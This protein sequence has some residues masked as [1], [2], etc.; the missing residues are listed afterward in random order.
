MNNILV[1]PPEP[2]AGAPLSHPPIG[3]L[4]MDQG[5]IAHEDLMHALELQRRID[6]PLGDIMVSEGL[7]ERRDVLSALAVQARTQGADLLLHPPARE[8]ARTLPVELCL[9]YGVVPWRMDARALYVAPASPA[10]FAALRARMQDTP[11]PIFPVIV[12][13]SQIGAQ[14]NRLYGQELARK[15]AER[16]PLA[17][18]CR[19]WDVAS[20]RRSRWSLAVVAGAALLAL[21]AP[22]LTLTILTLLATLML[23]MTTSLKLAALI[24]HLAP[25]PAVRFLHRLSPASMLKRLKPSPRRPLP[26]DAGLMPLGAAHTDALL[27]AA[28]VARAGKNGGLPVIN[29]ADRPFRLPRVSV[30]VPLLREREIADQLIARLSRLTYPKSLLDVVLVLEAGDELTRE[31]IARTAL[32]DWMRVIEVP[33][34]GNLTTKPRAL[35][36]ALDFCRGSIIGVWDAEDWPENDQIEKVVARFAKA[37]PDVACLQ[38]ALDYYNSRTNWLT[39]CFAIEYAIWWRVVLP[40]I[41]RLGLVVPLGGTTLFFRRVIL[42]ELGGWDAHNVTEDA[43]LGV[44]LARHGYRTELLATVTREEATSR[45]WPWVRQRSRWLKGFLITYLVHMRRPRGLLRDLGVWR[46]MGIQVLFLAS[47][48]QF[49]VAPLLWSFWL[50]LAGMSHPV[51]TTLGETAIGGMVAIFVVAETLGLLLGLVAVSH[52]EHRHLLPFLPTMMVY[53][54]LGTLA[55][56]KALWELVRV[57]FYWDKTQHGV[58]TAT[59]PQIAASGM[60][61]PQRSS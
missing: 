44:R 12:D 10:R 33:E 14:Q 36:Y 23:L 55:A 21:A 39:R 37:P 59:D 24:A 31:T 11:V 30:L 46:F 38:G 60:D 40:G 25:A 27:K 26:P 28:A 47:V 1:P 41:A 29:A 34:A 42:E 5:K 13:E 57:P 22:A 61:V 58:S 54:G 43:D 18:S 35:N 56:Y 45:P 48:S 15:A 19:S 8:M 20:A 17:E 53:F 9:E 4:L 32:P 16:V 49:V 50:I 51:A 3:R 7:V 6:A 2:G 52:R